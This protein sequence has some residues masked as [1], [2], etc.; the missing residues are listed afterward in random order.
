[1]DVVARAQSKQVLVDCS[2]PSRVVVTG[3]A[4]SRKVDIWL[5]TVT[6]CN[7]LMCKIVYTDLYL[8]PERKNKQLMLS[9]C[10]VH[11][12]PRAPT[13]LCVRPRSRTTTFDS[14]ESA[15]LVLLASTAAVRVQYHARMCS[16]PWHLPTS[17]SCSAT[18][19]LALGRSS[20]SDPSW[21]CGRCEQERRTD[22]RMLT[23]ETWSR[24]CMVAGQAAPRN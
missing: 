3:N 20:S 19:R 1:M 10:P 2:T 18:F 12:T 23:A 24:T 11:L 6:V 22:D 14:L 15:A 13:P 5:L 9:Q 4:R 8:N 21:W 7:K 16:Q 17:R